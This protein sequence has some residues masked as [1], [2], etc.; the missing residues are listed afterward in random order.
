MARN[1]TQNNSAR[2]YHNGTLVEVVRR[3]DKNS[4]VRIPGRTETHLVATASL[5]NWSK[6]EKVKVV[7]EIPVEAS[8]VADARPADEQDIEMGHATNLEGQIDVTIR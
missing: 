8:T 3:G 7:S 6:I 2:A 4:R 1:N 5:T